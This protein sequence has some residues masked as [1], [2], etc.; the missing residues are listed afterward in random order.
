MRMPVDL[1]LKLADVEQRDDEITNTLF[2]VVHYKPSI[3]GWGLL[4]DVHDAM[5]VADIEVVVAVVAEVRV[6]AWALLEA[7]IRRTPR[8]L[9]E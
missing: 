4:V 6:D 9:T 5:V 2:C 3:S 1:C 7:I 8:A